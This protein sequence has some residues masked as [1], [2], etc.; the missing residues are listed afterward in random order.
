VVPLK[1]ESVK[2]FEDVCFMF[3]NVPACLFLL[4]ESGD[5]TSE[6]AMIFSHLKAPV[7]SIPTSPI[8]HCRIL[9]PSVA[10][11]SSTAESSACPRVEEI[12]DTG[13]PA[14]SRCE[15]KVLLAM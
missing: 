1:A 2:G 7:G 4:D 14:A 9:G 6:G 5:I 10:R 8:A 3:V 12:I 11:Y 13:F 15:A